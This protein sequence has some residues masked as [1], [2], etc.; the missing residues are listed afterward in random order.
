MTCLFKKRLD[1]NTKEKYDTLRNQIASTRDNR[2]LLT[3]NFTISYPVDASMI[4]PSVLLELPENI[5]W[6]L[7]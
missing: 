3:G 7:S 5:F 4:I 2:I 1:A 6:H